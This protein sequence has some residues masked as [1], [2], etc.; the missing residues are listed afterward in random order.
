MTL[1]KLTSARLFC[2]VMLWIAELWF[3]HLA[4]ILQASL[5]NCRDIWVASIVSTKSSVGM[6]GSTTEQFSIREARGLI[7]DLATPKPWIYWVD[8]LASILAGHVAFGLL[9]RLHTW[10]VAWLQSAVSLWVARSALFTITAICYMRAIMFTHELVH[11]PTQGFAAFR[12]AWNLLC[13]IPLLVPSFLYYPHVEHHRRK[14]YGTEKD[15]E[16]IE[17]SHRHPSN[18]LLFIAAAAVVPAAAFVRFTLMTPL[19]WFV[20]GFRRWMEQ[21]ASSMIID[22]FYLRGDFGVQSRKIMR[23]QEFACWAWC[24]GLIAAWAS[25]IMVS[26]TPVFGYLLAVTLVLMNN[27]RTLGAHRWTGDGHELSFEQQL[28]DSLNYPHR[29]WITELW[30]PIGTRYHALHHLFPSLPYHNLGSAHRR[31]MAG[32]PA[33]SIYRQ[34]ER[35]SLFAEIAALWRRASLESSAGRHAQFDVGIRSAQDRR[36]A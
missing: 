4:F 30:G 13:G 11:L 20:P 24:L 2:E 5:R 28:L 36:A 25:G 27:I 14:H 1:K 26:T 17:L 29:A 6:M 12:I 31:L 18:I 9:A 32:L 33:D 3:L 10:D 21:H 23:L 19:A 15:G 34:T 22:I 7:K 35:V 16:Y 8:F